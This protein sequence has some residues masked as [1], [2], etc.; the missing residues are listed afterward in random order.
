VVGVNVQVPPGR[1]VIEPLHEQPEL[2]VGHLRPVVLGVRDA[3]L[4]R[5]AGRPLPERQLLVVRPGRGVDDSLVQPAVVRHDPPS[6][7]V[8]YGEVMPPFQ[9][10][11]PP[12]TTP[13]ERELLLRWLSDPRR[14]GL[15]E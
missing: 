6:Y 14:A 2:L 11:A 13:D 15:T 7:S 12:R 10:P 4:H 9:A 5:L 1:P 8:V 3:L